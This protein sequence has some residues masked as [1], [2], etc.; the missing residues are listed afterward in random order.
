MNGDT[1]IAT[2]AMQ[3][4]EKKTYTNAMEVTSVH[5]CLTVQSLPVCAKKP[6]SPWAFKTLYCWLVNLK[7]LIRLAMQ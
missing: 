7:L 2:L 4:R 1:L 5:Y 3:V 6:V